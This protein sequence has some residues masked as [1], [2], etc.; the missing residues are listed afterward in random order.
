MDRHTR[1]DFVSSPVLAVAAYG[2]PAAALVAVNFLE[3]T[4][5]FAATLLIIAAALAWAG[6]AC[7]LNALRC[8]RTHCYVSG[9]IL[10]LGAAATLLFGF[11][12]ISPG[13]SALDTVIWGTFA[14]VALSFATELIWGRY[15][16]RSRG[17]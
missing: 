3:D 17:T 1:T 2:I 10:L 16:G 11:G 15:V 6:V 5:P 4:I 13:P 7:V 12:V 9:P 14:L 8:G